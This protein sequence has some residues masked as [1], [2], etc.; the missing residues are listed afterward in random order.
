[1]KIKNILSVFLNPFISP[2]IISAIIAFVLMFSVIPDLSY[3][4]KLVVLEKE[5]IDSITKL[6]KIRS[7]YTQNVISKVNKSEDIKVNF[8]YHSKVMTIPLPA[9]LMH[10]LSDLLPQNDTT[11]KMFS[12]YPFPNRANRILDDSQKEAL[13]YVE[14]NKNK[15]HT[16]IVHEKNQEFLKVTV[17]DVF[18]DRSCVQCHNSRMDT[19]KNDWSLGDV[20]GAIQVT[21]PIDI[22]IMLSSE[23]T[24]VLF[25]FLLVLVLI[26]GLHYSIVSY[27]NKKKLSVHNEILDEKI[28]ERTKTLNEYK[29]A[30]DSS[31]I[32]SKTNS[33]GKIT[34]V[35]DEFINISQFSE[36]E[37]IGSNHNIIRD[38]NMKDEVFVDLWATIKAK[39]IWK[40]QISNRAKDGSIYY[41]SSTIVPIL[42]SQNE[43]EEFL[44]IRLDVT[45]V[46]KS[47]LEAQRANNVKSTFLANISHEIRTPLNAIMGFSQVLNSSNTL[48]LEN[49][50]QVEIINTSANNLLE[51]INDILDISKIENGNFDIA[52][53]DTNIHFIAQQTVELFSQKAKQ[54]NI[55][56]IFDIDSAIPHCIQTD[57]IRLRQVLSN[58]LGNSIKFT[59]KEGEV[60]LNIHILENNNSKIQIRF[61]VIDN[62][63]GI[64]INSQKKVFEPFV[65]ADSNTN[66]K[67]EGTGLGLSI[68]S[69]I[70]KSLNG[71]INLDSQPNKGSKF[72]FDL[73]FDTCD[74]SYFKK[75]NHFKKLNS[76]VDDFNDSSIKDINGNILIAEDNLTNQELI[77]YIMNE[78]NID[79]TI[80]SNGEEAVNKFM[81]EKFDLIL[82]DINMPV[83]D[84]IDA[85]K[86]IRKYEQF[87]NLTAIPIIALTAN[88]IKGDK[89]K[90]IALGMN[91]YLSK[92]I[93]TQKLEEIL[94]Q[95]LQK[96]ICNLSEHIKSDERDDIV[97]VQ[98]MDSFD[99]T[100]ISSKL[101]ISEP[102]VEM[103]IKKFSEDIMDDLDELSH[104]ISIQDFENISKKAHYI[105]NSC[106]NL[107]LE[108]CCSILQQIE[109]ET[110][111]ID[112][113]E[114]LFKQ[115]K[116]NLTTIIQAEIK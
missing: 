92:P 13:L 20:R 95:Y 59:H 44:A 18:L 39:K 52:N 41:V 64:D 42:N 116:N 99:S 4:N 17:A 51:I 111:E 47:K 86:N 67:Y 103:L 46:V 81:S 93:Q 65:Q 87:K 9:T 10:D 106:L 1:M 50:K 60:K 85:F 107:M 78:L 38:P 110:K 84:G 57:G 14:K 30:V 27:L 55:R 54:K 45:D 37:L 75:E 72:W 15:V 77:G 89:E 102:I 58:L 115:L 112:S 105:K 100:H 114:Q 48:S 3:Q 24:F 28:N 88:A 12:N 21:L 6:K 32:V 80:V 43:I 25:V 56:F 90:F 79:Y 69:Y 23:E 104:F 16:K 82:M 2:I 26:L 91:D 36:E 53:E 63:I 94:I 22:G 7:Y 101:G 35:N 74:E 31:A 11:I 19:P 68:C 76:S 71:N 97:K 66:R 34:Y 62:G 40:G 83:M 108:E 5:A 96:N 109:T 33:A 29:K 113:I 49:K 61:E 73:E 8:D 70:V 98:V